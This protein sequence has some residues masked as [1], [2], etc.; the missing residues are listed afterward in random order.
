MLLLSTLVLFTLQL[1]TS[2]ALSEGTL[3]GAKPGCL[4]KCGEVTVPYPFG[5][6]TIAMANGSV[7]QHEYCSLEETFGLTCN[8]TSKSPELF[9]G[10]RNLKIHNI[11]ESEI[12]IFNSIAYRCYDRG[13]PPHIFTEEQAHCG[14][15]RYYAWI[16][17][18][19][20]SNYASGCMGLCND[21]SRVPS[22]GTCSGIGC[23]QTSIP[24]GFIYFNISLGSFNNH[25]NV[26]KSNRCGFA[27][28]GEEGSFQ[29]GGARD[30]SNATEFYFKTRSSVHR[31]LDWV[32]GRNQSCSQPTACKGNSF[33]RDAPADI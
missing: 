6:N 27:F 2:M 17:G 28:L 32:I 10:K 24:P 1:I 19:T 13:V 8:F 21:S 30:M 29:F 18:P 16:R 31:V 14:R 4:S 3:I 9:I 7:T 20:G 22:N 5:I 25:I 12:R 23:C 15:M 33:C 11:S 26:V